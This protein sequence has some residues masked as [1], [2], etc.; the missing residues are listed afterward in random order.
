VFFAE[1]DIVAAGSI[2]ENEP[3]LSTLLQLFTVPIRISAHIKEPG[4]GRLP[5]T[6]RTGTGLTIRYNN[7]FNPT[8]REALGIPINNNP[9]IEDIV[10]YKVKG[11]EITSVHDKSGLDIDTIKLVKGQITPI[12]VESGYSYFLD[13]LTENSLDSTTT[14]YGNR[15]QERH[16]IYRQFQLDEGEKSGVKNTD[17]LDINS[18]SGKITMPSNK[19]IQHVTFWVTV[20]DEVV[21]ERMRPE[22]STLGEAMAVLEYK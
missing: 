4:P 21:N 6:I 13:A 11:E 5:H 20:K 3:F 9:V 14:M 10:V 1:N 8:D 22:G 16:E 2:G 15:V 18:F 7:K 17:Y 19:K 12:P